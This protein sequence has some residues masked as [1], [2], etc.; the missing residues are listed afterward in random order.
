ME[1]TCLGKNAQQ[2]K[3]SNKLK[4]KTVKTVELEE[5]LSFSINTVKKS[6]VISVTPRTE[7]KNLKMD[8]GSAF[9]VIPIK[10]CKEMFSTKRYTNKSLRLIQAR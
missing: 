10:T 6:E 3:G 7:E 8:T 4:S 9:S 2:R 1:K 5:L